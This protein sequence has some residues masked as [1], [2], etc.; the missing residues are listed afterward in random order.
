MIARNVVLYSLRKAGISHLV[1]KT[2]KVDLLSRLPVLLRF[3][4]LHFVSKR[5]AAVNQCQTPE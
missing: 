1:P 4:I 2:R 3:R 5:I